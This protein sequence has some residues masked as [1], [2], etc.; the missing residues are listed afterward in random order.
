MQ[1]DSLGARCSHA[2]ACDSQ[3]IRPKV[4]SVTYSR[5][6]SCRLSEAWRSEFWPPAAAE[7]ALALVSTL[8]RKCAWLS[9]GIARRQ[10]AVAVPGVRSGFM[11]CSV[12]SALELQCPEDLLYHSEWRGTFSC[13]LRMTRYISEACVHK[14]LQI[15]TVASVCQRSGACAGSAA[16]AARQAHAAGKDGR[17]LPEHGIPGLGAARRSLHQRCALDVALPAGGCWAPPAVGS[18]RFDSSSSTQW[19]PPLAQSCHS[20]SKAELE[21]T[22]LHKSSPPAATAWDAMPNPM[23]L[24]TDSREGSGTVLS[25]EAEAYAG[26]KQ[27]WTLKLARSVSSVF[28]DKTAAYRRRSNF[29]GFAS[30]GTDSRYLVINSRFLGICCSAR[31]S[32]FCPERGPCALATCS[33]R[34]QARC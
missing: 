3:L 23:M 2:C 27:K 15:L 25:C 5:S 13:Y 11:C 16:E 28:A 33:C 21:S 22:V 29:E 19:S 7:S 12:L 26:F 8:A 32:Q 18:G 14:Q 17:G 9:I 30:Y 20:D 6:P 4:L 34:L 1:E 24:A 31:P 10:F